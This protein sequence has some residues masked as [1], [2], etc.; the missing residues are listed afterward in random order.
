MARIPTTDSDVKEILETELDTTPF[1]E[2]AKL[3]VDEDLVGKGLSD[4][5]LEQIELYL[6]AHFTTLRERQLESE[7]F[8]DSKDRLLGQ[9]EMGLDSS[10]YGQQAKVL[11]NTGTLVNLGKAKAEF[12]VIC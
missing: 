10:I 2:T 11:D 12:Q 8:G 4:A 1:I 7:E 9:V 6:S 3:I 5:R